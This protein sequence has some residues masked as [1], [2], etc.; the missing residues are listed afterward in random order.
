MCDGWRCYSSYIQPNLG[1]LQYAIDVPEHL[2]KFTWKKCKKIDLLLEVDLKAE[3]SS[4]LNEVDTKLLNS[5]WKNVWEST[6]RFWW[7]LDGLSVG[8]SGAF[9]AVGFHRKWNKFTHLCA[10]FS[11]SFL[12][13]LYI[14]WIFSIIILSLLRVCSCFLTSFSCWYQ[15]YVSLY[16]A[17]FILKSNHYHKQK[18]QLIFESVSA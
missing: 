4:S 8:N 16:Y 13:M 17:F 6:W 1:R 2:V 11:F 14:L 3:S 12:F 7:A 9:E 15:S 18:S 10:L 5:A